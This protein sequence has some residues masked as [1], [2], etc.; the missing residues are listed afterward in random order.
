MRLFRDVAPVPPEVTASGAPRVSVPKKA[1]VDDAY[2]EEIAVVE[3][4][5][6]DNLPVPKLIA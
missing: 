6:K 3:A 4:Y 1:L 2:E 5:V